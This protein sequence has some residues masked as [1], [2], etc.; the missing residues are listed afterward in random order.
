[1][2]PQTKS[3]LTNVLAHP[4]VTT[5]AMA[6][7]PKAASEVASAVQSSP[8]IAIVPVKSAL[9]S[10]INWTQLVMIAAMILAMFGLNITPAE[11]AAI[12]TTLGVVGGLIT[13]V[14]KTWFTNSVTSASA[15]K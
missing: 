14:V 9:A 3:A 6:D 7:A 13:I 5:V 4:S 15:G 12:V 1:M 8:D 2:D 10:K 11:Q